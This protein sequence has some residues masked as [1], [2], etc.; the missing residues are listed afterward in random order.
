MGFTIMVC[1]TS[2]L[3]ALIMRNDN[4]ESSISVN[5]RCDDD[6]GSQKIETL[7]KGLVDKF[8]CSSLCPCPDINF[9]ISDQFRN[10]GRASAWDMTPQE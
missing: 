3:L 5:E 10:S 1:S 4:I 8:M 9:F 2:S 7:Y 6:G